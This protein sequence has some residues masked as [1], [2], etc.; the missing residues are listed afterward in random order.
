MS[1]K[2]R[3][4]ENEH[5]SGDS[6]KT[7]YEIERCTQG[8]LG[9]YFDSWITVLTLTAEEMQVLRDQFEDLSRVRRHRR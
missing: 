7:T 4:V 5:E 8:E 6:A 1:E 9:A 2:I 3:V